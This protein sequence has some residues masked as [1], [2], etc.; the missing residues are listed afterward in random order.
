[1][2][3]VID[4]IFYGFL[5]IFGLGVLGVFTWMLYNAYTYKG[6]DCGR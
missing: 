4:C 6:D 2:I 1:M 3:E 5:T